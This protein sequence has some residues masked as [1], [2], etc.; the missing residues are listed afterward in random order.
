MSDAATLVIVYH[1]RRHHSMVDVEKDTAYGL[2]PHQ[3]AG[4][5][6]MHGQSGVPAL[7]L[8]VSAVKPH[9]RTLNLQC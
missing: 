6:V 2:G 5:G 3:R 8:N 1:H 9:S 4:G 7:D